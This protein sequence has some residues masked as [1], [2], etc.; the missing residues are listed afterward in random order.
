[1]IGGAGAPQQ[2]AGITTLPGLDALEHWASGL[3]A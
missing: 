3:M 1:V 2:I